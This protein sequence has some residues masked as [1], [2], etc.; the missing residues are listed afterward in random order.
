M[1][2]RRQ[3]ARVRRSLAEDDSSSGFG[4]SVKLEERTWHTKTTSR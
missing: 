2:V 4:I 3:R 1:A